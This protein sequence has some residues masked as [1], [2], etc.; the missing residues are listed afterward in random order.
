MTTVKN[1]KC[2]QPTLAAFGFKKKVVHHDVETA[3]KLP[4]LKKLCI[5]ATNT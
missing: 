4:L 1:I 3:V 5:N 2:K